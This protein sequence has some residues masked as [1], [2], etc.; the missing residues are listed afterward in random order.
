MRDEY[1][2][3]VAKIAVGDE[4]FIFL[5]GDLGFNA[6][7]GIRDQIGERFINAGV[8]EQNMIDVAAGMAYAGLNPWTYSIAPF[9]VLKTLEQVRND[10]SHKNLAVK[11]VGNGGGYGYGIMGSTHHVLEDIAIMS[12]MPSIKI[13]I[14]AFNSDVA[15]IVAKMNERNGP[16]YLRLGASSLSWKTYGAARNVLKGEK[17]VVAA[18]GPVVQNVISAAEK[19]EGVD[20]WAIT[21]LPFSLPTSFYKSLLKTK[22]MLVVEEH[23]QSGG[24]GQALLSALAQRSLC[25]KF[26]HSFSKGYISKLYGS[27]SYHLKDAGLD[28][29]SIYKQIQHLING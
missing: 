5:T 20:V 2:K 11:M 8:A 18:L 14:P 3:A 19:I 6:F 9:L 1:A 24:L 16:S 28:D 29:K 13:F 12:S 17:I 25:V 27:Q 21:E 10:I 26:A 23:V 15:P 22:K 4:K 7:E